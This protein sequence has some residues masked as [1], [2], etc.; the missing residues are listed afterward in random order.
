MHR[1][2][3]AFCFN[4]VINAW[5]SL[6]PSNTFAPKMAEELINILSIY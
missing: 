3:R 6:P 2:S 5:G 4:I 1:L